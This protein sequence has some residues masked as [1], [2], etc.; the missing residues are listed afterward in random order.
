M[1][2]IFFLIVTAIL[3]LPSFV[4]AQ[5]DLRNKMNPVSWW[6][7]WNP[8][9]LEAT[10]DTSNNWEWNPLMTLFWF[11]RDFLFDILW[12]ITVW[13]FLYFWFK[14][15]SAQ[16]NPEEM[17]KVIVWFVYVVIWLAIIPLSLAAVRLVSSLNF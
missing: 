14:L 10:S 3:L 12:V 4:F 11:F 15:I 17:K 5:N 2:K 9:L 8:V 13:V 6:M 7:W 1:K 16:W